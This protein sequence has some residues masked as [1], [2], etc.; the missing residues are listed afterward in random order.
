MTIW[1]YLSNDVTSASSWEALPLAS[2]RGI[3]KPN[4]NSLSWS[5]FRISLSWSL[6]IFIQKKSKGDDN[7]TNW[8]S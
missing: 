5:R 1:T 8:L 2:S 6:F 7:L 4:F 3:D